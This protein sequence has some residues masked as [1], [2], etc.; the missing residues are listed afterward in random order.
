MSQKSDGSEDIAKT[1][2]TQHARRSTLQHIAHNPA[3]RFTFEH[4]RPSRLH[5]SPLT[6]QALSVMSAKFG[7]VQTLAFGPPSTCDANLPTKRPGYDSIDYFCTT[8]DITKQLS[9]NAVACAKLLQLQLLPNLFPAAAA[10]LQATCPVLL[11][12]VRPKH[13]SCRPV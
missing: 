7:A 10:E 13:N 3:C 9:T 6:A 11:F 4:L 8:V 1:T 12:R 5:E 2:P